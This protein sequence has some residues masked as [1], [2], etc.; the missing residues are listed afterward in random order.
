[1]SGLVRLDEIRDKWEQ[2]KNSSRVLRQMDSE[3]I[4]PQLLISKV[5]SILSQSSQFV[6]STCALVQD[7]L[8]E[9]SCL[10]QMQ[11][12]EAI[13]FVLDYL[14][15]EYPE[16]FLN[17]EKMGQRLE[18]NPSILEK[19]DGMS[20]HA[21]ALKGSHF[22]R[23]WVD[24]FEDQDPDLPSF[25]RAHALWT[26][27][28]NLCDRV[29]PAVQA[30]WDTF[31][32]G[33]LSAPIKNGTTDAFSQ[34]VVKS[35]YSI[36]EIY[37]PFLHISISDQM[38]V[39]PDALLQSVDRVSFDSTL[40][41]G[42]VIDFLKRM[43]H[44]TGLSFTENRVLSADFVSSLP[45]ELLKRL[46]ELNLS[47]APESSGLPQLLA[48]VPN[49]QRL[50]IVDAGPLLELP[51]VKKLK[52][53]NSSVDP[54]VLVNLNLISLHLENVG[55]IKL[56]EGAAFPH[57]KELILEDA[58]F[59]PQDLLRLFA[60]SHLEKL[61]M[62]NAHQL[63]DSVIAQIPK[64]AFTRLVELHLSCLSSLETTELADLLWLAPHLNRLTI[65][66]TRSGSIKILTPPKVFPPLDNLEEVH[67][68]D[69]A[70][71]IQG[72][73]LFLRLAN[74][75]TV[76]NLQDACFSS[77]Q[78]TPVYLSA[79]DQLPQ[80]I[81]P[82]LRELNLSIK[83]GSYHLSPIIKQ[84]LKNILS[85]ATRLQKLSV[86]EVFD[87]ELV[88]LISGLY[89]LTDL[90]LDRYAYID[91][92][93]LVNERIVKVLSSLPNLRTL[94]LATPD[95]SNRLCAHKLPP[96]ALHRLKRL[97]LI[98][99]IS[100]QDVNELLQRTHRLKK[101]TVSDNYRF[102]GS[103]LRHLPKE[104]LAHLQVVQLSYTDIAN[105]GLN[106]LLNQALDIQELV[107][108][109]CTKIN[110]QFTSNL[111]PRALSKLLDLDLGADEDAFHAAQYPAPTISEQG[112]REI[113][114][115]AQHLKQL[116][117]VNNRSVKKELFSQLPPHSLSHVESLDLTGVRITHLE[118]ISSGVFARLK[119]LNL[120][121]SS[122]DI[123]G[124]FDLLHHTPS[125]RF[126][127]YYSL[128]SIEPQPQ[129]EPISFSQTLRN[130]FFSTPLPLPM[131]RPTEPAQLSIDLPYLQSV[132]ISH[133]KE[134]EVCE[135]LNRTSRL[136]F[137]AIITGSG[138][139]NGSLIA[140]LPMDRFSHLERLIFP[141]ASP[142]QPWSETLP[143]NL[144]QIREKLPPHALLE[145]F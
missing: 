136:Q 131:P 129:P 137:L 49:L 99:A 6:A 72:V 37:S 13:A 48:V 28:L 82:H 144:R 96:H 128:F 19:L 143:E 93:S 127:D 12:P 95:L 141:R 92:S 79:H 121:H 80:G 125:L 120:E 23:A 112:M 56:P 29:Q 86:R 30:A 21:D 62:K 75:L 106:H 133:I 73:D 132:R 33:A 8:D 47:V 65:A 60:H 84:P 74:N 46:Q 24:Y 45:S 85:S 44:V 117:L 50:S 22:W 89:Y 52:L 83:R 113:A 105:N 94:S 87:E 123:H 97:S 130:I 15:P 66:H 2:L 27:Y 142:P 90:Y 16:N 67:F 78:Q 38:G 118:G 101:L 35:P 100:D 9:A 107:L 140:A 3:Y 109:S 108:K 115:R 51:P 10:F 70:F 17:L 126:L 18:Q 32:Q 36:P 139:M 57:L 26:L 63:T 43:P 134:P 122:F 88:Q 145:I 53:V 39:I 41:D 25:R 119:S 135:L 5:M 7:P 124:I 54:Q 14:T 31:C 68:I 11:S 77:P 114:S 138:P 116:T 59:D 98:D 61:V 20:L 64:Q 58:P 103:L 69:A 76:L 34:L 111:N 71:Q 40:N 110:D 4:V 1:M 81:L 104:K 42:A 55:K 91:Q 102:T